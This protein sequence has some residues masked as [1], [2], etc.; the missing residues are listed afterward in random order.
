M[1]Q[2]PAAQAAAPQANSP[3]YLPGSHQRARWLR[4]DAARI[5]KRLFFCERAL[6]V[7][8]S[9]WLAAIPD[10]ETKLALPGLSWQDA[11]TAHALRERVFELRYPSRLM[12]VAEDAPV[13]DLFLA[14]Q[15]APSAGALL[16]AL[17]RVFKPAQ[18]AAYQEYISLA[19][20]LSDGPIL[21]ALR[22]AV[23]EKSEQIGMLTRLAAAA[24]H[25][26]PAAQE[27]AAAWVSALGA[28]LIQ[29]GG[30][31]VEDPLAAPATPLPRRTPF[32]LAE[33]P[34]RDSRF[35]LC[36]YYWPDVVDPSFGYGE[37]ISLQLR[38]AVSHFNEVWAVETGG[39]VLHA[40]ADD[41]EWEFIYD[42][43]RWTYDEA[44][45]ARMGLERLQTWGF[46]P[47]D[48]PLGTYIYDSARGQDPVVRLGMLHYFETKNIGKK[49]RRAAAFAS[50]NDRMS[51][52]DMDFDWADETIHA[53]YG[54]R[55]LEAL[56]DRFPQRVPEIDALRVLC[57]DLVAQQVAAATDADRAAIRRVAQSMIEKAQRLG[58]ERQPPA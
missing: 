21:R 39:A 33:V 48:L 24:L 7:A 43:A 23:L 44:R 47:A 20:E 6:V 4:M 56:H 34:A 18:L 42:A 35:F 53:E 32:A 16:L 54:H 2:T 17:A 19:D 10:V 46:A 5:L 30:L 29:V 25:D 36:R 55:W 13:V 12:E 49:T 9:G 41:L 15:H 40:F 8:Q 26:D 37:G 27:A 28:R 38:S 1:A 14:A 51:Q 45:H 11:M 50:Y 31:S 3:V 58:L 52:H 57:D 22:L